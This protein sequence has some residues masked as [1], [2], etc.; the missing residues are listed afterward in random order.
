MAELKLTELGTKTSKTTIDAGPW[1]TLSLSAPVRQ[2]TP[3]QTWK[4]A[5]QTYGTLGGELEAELIHDLKSGVRCFFFTRSHVTESHWNIIEKTLSGS[6]SANEL[7]VF[8]LGPREGAA[9][10]TSLKLYQEP[11]LL[12]A[13]AVHDEGGNTVQELALLT[14]KLIESLGKT[15][16]HGVGVFVDSQFFKNIAKLRAL[17]LLGMKV[18]QEAQVKADLRIIALTSLREWTLYER[19]SNMLRNDA[20]VASSYI[21]GADSVQSTGYHYLHDVMGLPAGDHRERSLRMARNTSHILALESMLGVVHDAASGSYHLE[22]LTE[23]FAAEAWALMQA[24]L[25]LTTDQREQKLREEVSIVREKRLQAVNTRK[26]VLAGMN[27]YPDAKESLGARPA[28]PSPCFRIAQG[29]E[30]LRLSMEALPTRPEVFIGIHGDYAS[31]NA[32]LNFVKNHFQLLG[33][34]VHEVFDL[35]V[36]SQ[37]QGITVLCAADED[38][39][40]FDKVPF[41][42]EDRYIAG[43]VPRE[44]FTNLFMGQNVEELLRKLVGKWGKK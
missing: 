38:Y 21:G 10:N 22:G 12:T 44:G 1:P 29:F 31:L 23:K 32:R 42:S 41:R 5:A 39:G 33:L 11:T 3:S 2:L 9:V 27:D 13:R 36:L 14:L 17:R 16:E 34:T 35:S 7:E 6:S 25:P 18:L 37:H 30:E 40:A 28:K 4:K 8:L 43:K 24:L 15:T 26:H 19:Y 20:A